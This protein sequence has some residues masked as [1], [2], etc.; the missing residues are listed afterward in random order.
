MVC[1]GEQ[2]SRATAC[3]AASPPPTTYNKTPLADP[4]LQRIAAV[5]A[6]KPSAREAGLTLGA[7]RGWAAARLPPY[8]LPA[9]L[10]L[11]PAIPRNAM[12]K[13]NKKS[14]RAELFPEAAAPPASAA[15]AGA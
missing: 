3:I 4:L 12:G 13:V 6:L 14:L 15:G 9:A 7:L 2:G 11:V 1:V 8:Q 10:Q 5:A